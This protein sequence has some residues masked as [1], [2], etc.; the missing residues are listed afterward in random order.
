MTMWFHVSSMR[1]L[2]ARRRG[3]C[4]RMMLTAFV[5]TLWCL[6][7]AAWALG[8]WRDTERMAA[9]VRMD[10]ML[11]AGT[12]D[13]VIRSLVHTLRTMPS[14]GGVEWRTPERMW[15]E[16][17]R[18]LRLDDDLRTVVDVPDVVRL[19]PSDAALNERS[20]TLL[21]SACEDSWPDVYKVVW[22]IDYV[23]A[24]DSRRRDVMILGGAAAVLSFILF[25]TALLHA[26]R[27]ELHRAEQDMRIGASMGATPSFMAA[28]HL[29]IGIV[30]GS[31]GLS[32]AVG[33]ISVSWS[34]ILAT[35]P[36]M[37]TV[38]TEEFAMWVGILAVGGLAIC[39]WQGRNAARRAGRR[40]T[41]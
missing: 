22:P 5:G 20:M 4:I 25:M 39:W 10:V 40:R 9:D 36:W 31:I 37:G 29:L 3:P 16:F 2:M 13:S 11:H 8:T 26:F 7:G 6:V 30:T 28:P 14:V 34:S 35:M 23:R 41:A 19:R 33:L 38:R 1:R 17:S 27:S 12:P 15:S 32:L 21:A 18:D 24:I